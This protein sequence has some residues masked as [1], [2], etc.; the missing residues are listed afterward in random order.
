MLYQVNGL[1]DIHTVLVNERKMGGAVEAEFVR[2]R[3]GEEF[4][5]VAVTHI[6]MA[7]SII[8]SVSFITEEGKRYIIHIN[9]IS[10][11]SQPTHKHIKSL[12]N[13]FYKQLKTDE[14]IKYLTKLCQLNEDGFTKP[15]LQEVLH[16]IEDI[17]S[18]SAKK[19][20]DL[21]LIQ[22]TKV[23]KMEKRVS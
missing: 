17:G 14:K 10:M 4:T 20:M 2:L 11:I 23:V 18:D 6:D 3:S 16:I 5:N 21:D 22:D 12:N 8:Y 15:V 1:K 7:G 19:H 13:S 9:D